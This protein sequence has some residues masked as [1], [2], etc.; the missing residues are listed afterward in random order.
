[1]TTRALLAHLE[2]R[3]QG[4]QMQLCSAGC[5]SSHV[6]QQQYGPLGAHVAGSHAKSAGP[7]LLSLHHVPAEAHAVDA[8]LL[9]VGGGGHDLAACTHNN[10]QW[11]GRVWMRKQSA[12]SRGTNKRHV[13]H[14]I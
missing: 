1:M 12:E 3:L 5:R 9:L 7:V 13:T 6:Q 8:Q 11:M 14:E 10:Q 4:G 2:S